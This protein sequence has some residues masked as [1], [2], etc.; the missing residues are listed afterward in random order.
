AGERVLRIFADRVRA[1]TRAVDQLVRSG[2]DEFVLIMPGADRESALGIAQRIRA[3]MADDPIVLDGGH[4]V[5]VRVS[6]GVA[7]WDGR[8]SA[9]DLERRADQA[10]Y[11]VKEAG[12]D[13]VRY[14][15]D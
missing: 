11:S 6:V 10:M 7:T 8:E 3:T 2:G 5:E 12:R 9:A 13:G 1:R 15:D 14:Y 4:R